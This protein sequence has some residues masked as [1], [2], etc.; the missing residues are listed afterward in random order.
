MSSRARVASLLVSQPEIFCWVFSG[1]TPRSLML[2]VGHT[3]VS[4]Q[5]R[6][7]QL[8][9]GAGDVLALVQHRGQVGSVMR[10]LVLD[11]RVGLQDGLELRAGVG[12]FPDLGG[13]PEEPGD[14][15]LVPGEQDC[16]DGGEVRVQRGGPDAGLHGDP[17]IVA[18]G[19]VL[20][21]RRQGQPRPRWIASAASSDLERMPSLANM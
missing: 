14:L 9:A 8:M 19:R 4:E 11:E 20:A 1:R 6:R 7:V 18:A 2:L 16:L 15:A 21:V 5:N 17:H 10:V 12:G 3:R 13:L